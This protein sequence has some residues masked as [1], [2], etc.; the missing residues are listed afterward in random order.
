MEEEE[1]GGGGWG[2]AT[3]SGVN[4][5][6]SFRSQLAPEERQW[7]GKLNLKEGETVPTGDRGAL[8]P[9]AL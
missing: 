4:E 5:V 6:H 1:V 3:D 9:N 8:R 7:G 2:W